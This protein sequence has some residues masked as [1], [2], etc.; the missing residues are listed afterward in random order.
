[1]TA[2]PQ[3]LADVV[4]ARTSGLN[5]FLA[6]EPTVRGDLALALQLDG[7]FGG[8]TTRD[9]THPRAFSVDAMGAATSYLEPVRPTG[10][11]SCCRPRRWR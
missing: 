7:L 4:P 8:D 6:G 11:R 1:V 10:P 2:R 3:A 9:V 5:A